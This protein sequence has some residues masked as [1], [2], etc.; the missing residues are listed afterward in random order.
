MTDAPSKDLSTAFIECS[1]A[2][3]SGDA[4]GIAAYAQVLSPSFDFS[5]PDQAVAEPFS[6]HA[7]VFFLPDVIVSRARSTACRLTRTAR[8][9]A[10]RGT[11]QILVVTYTQGPFDLTVDNETRRVE[12]GEIV[13]ID[14]S[15]E[16]A[17]DAPRVDNIGLAISRRRLEALVPFLDAAHGFVRPDDAVSRLLRS[18]MEQILQSGPTLRVVDAR[19]IADALVQLVATAIA[20]RS[21]QMADQGRATASLV[22]I[23]AHIEEH[24]LDRALGPQSLLDAFGVTRST[25]YRLFEPLGGVSSYIVRRRLNYA[26][27]RLSDTRTARDR[28]SRLAEELGYSHPSAF[29]RAFKDTF[30]L[31]PKDV[32]ALA[33]HSRDQDIPLMTSREPLRHFTPVD[34]T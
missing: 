33:E 11:D 23:K 34:P 14:L 20:P 28:I 18:M 24:L 2:D 4:A 17:I 9:I 3:F 29:T 7:E 19:G 32:Q 6:A 27:R 30:G 8:T 31:S 16:I 21:R 15:R 12:P 1:S 22:A 26:F 13:C 10:A 5:I 25:L